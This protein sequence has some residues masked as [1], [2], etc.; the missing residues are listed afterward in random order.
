MHASLFE[1][2]FKLEPATPVPAIRPAADTC[3]RGTLSFFLGEKVPSL[4][5]PLLSVEVML[6]AERPVYT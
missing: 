2:K 3:P 5:G 6:M 1:L 4:T